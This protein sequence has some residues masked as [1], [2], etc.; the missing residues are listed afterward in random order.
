MAKGD[1]TTRPTTRMLEAIAGTTLQDDVFQQD[2]TTL[3]LESWIAELTGKEAALL[4]TWQQENADEVSCNMWMW[5]GLASRIAFGL[6]AN[7]D[8]SHHASVPMPTWDRRRYRFVWW[9]LFC[10]DLDLE[11]VCNGRP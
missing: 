9:T 6:G 8:L 2:P 4:F 7:R 11:W 1:V 10:T 5:T 3:H